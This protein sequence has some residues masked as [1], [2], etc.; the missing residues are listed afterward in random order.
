MTIITKDRKSHI[1]KS[2]FMEE[3]FDRFFNE[4]IIDSEKQYDKE[5]LKTIRDNVFDYVYSREELEADRLFD[6]IIRYS[7]DCI[8][9]KHPDFT[10]LSASALRRKLYKQ[11]SKNRGFDYKQGYGD[12]YSFVVQMVEQG[13]YDESLLEKYTEQE[14]RKAGRMI[15]KN[16]DKKFSYAG[17]YM[18]VN[19]YLKKGYNGEILELPQERFLS[20]ALYLMKDEVKSRRMKHVEESYWAL[21]NHYIGLA[22]PTLMNAGSPHGTLSSCHI[23]TP[24]D[25]L[26]S[27]MKSLEQTARFSQNGAGIGIFLGFLRAS[28][29]WIRG[30][31]GRATGI[32]HPSRLNS[33]LAEYVN[34]LGARVAG[35][36]LY[37][38]VWHY[39]IFDFLDLRLKTGSQELRAHSI[40]TAV[41][42]P[43]EFMRRLES[44]QNWTIFDPYEFRKKM[45]VDLN[46][47]YDK[48]KLMAD[49][50]PNEEDHAFT[51]WYRKAE[52]DM[53]FEIK[54]VVNATD[55]YRS[56]FTS[57]KTG[58]TPYLYFHDTAA[59]YNPNPHKGMPFGSNLCSEIIQNMDVDKHI[60]EDLDENGFV[61]T[62]VQGEGLVTCNLSSLVLNNVFN[63]E[64]SVDLQRVV[65]IQFRMLDNVISLNR[66]VV[67]QATYTNQQYRAVG[68]GAMGLVTLMTSRGI[69]WESEEASEFTGN[70]FKQYL[71]AMIK[72]SAKLAQE[73][74]SYP[75]FEG[76]DWQ[77]GEFFDKRGFV[78]DEWNEVRELASKGM[79]NA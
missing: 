43:D 30:Y 63:E 28:G 49:E 38:P 4:I 61:V 65:D 21:S 10:Y 75:L 71:K 36:S 50:E 74:G 69:R 66:T 44:K 14:I 34:Q 55:V 11:A 19:S 33:V 17:L 13:I 77:T 41:T 6:L 45:G 26:I 70:I 31:K 60:S 54:R 7:N 5:L 52:K 47:L 53:S 1:Q 25:D 39:D 20:T 2:E 22:T 73:K 3:R 79:R 35:I 8:S 59:R 15:D 29:S 72:A 42:L 32:L 12:Y 27:I 68:A 56:I 67:P 9:P 58:G 18:L 64:E 48:K 78:S 57:R 62:K 46:R 23:V 24:D 40:K 37:L 16:K 51:Y 76:S